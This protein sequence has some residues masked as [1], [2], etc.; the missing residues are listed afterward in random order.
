MKKPDTE[1]RANR[2]ATGCTDAK[3]Q[4][5]YPT[6]VEYLISAAWEDGSPRELSALSISC[7]D[8]CVALAMNDKELK[9]SLY[10][11]AGTLEEALK[12]MEGALVSGAGEWRSWKAG[13]KK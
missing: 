1:E 4:G 13:K 5:K 8:G 11:L 10:T 3:F 2:S 6:I 7:R 12:L 9:Q